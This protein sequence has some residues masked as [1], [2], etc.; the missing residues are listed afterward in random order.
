MPETTLWNRRFVFLLLAQTGFGFAHS[1]FLMLPKF[2]ATELAAGPAEIGGVVAVSAISIVLFL[3][4]AGSMVDRHGR[5]PFLVAGTLLMAV[6]SASYV[7]VHEI[8]AFLYALRLLQSLAFAY[9]FAAGGALCI[10]AAPPERIG[11]A[12]GL[13]GLSYIVMGAFAPAVVEGLVELRGWDACFWLTAATSTL[14]ATLSLFVREERVEPGATPHVPLTSIVA[15][16]EMRRATLVVGLLGIAFGCA[17]NFYQP[18]ALSL[19]ILELRDF[20]IAHSVAAASCRLALG[21]FIDRIGL[22][23]VSLGSLSLY[24]VVIFGMTWLDEIGLV[25]LGLGMG[26]AHGLFYPSYTGT[27]LMGCPAAERGRRMSIIQAGLNVGV[28][29]AGIVLGT[30]AAR[31]GYPIVFQIA[32][33]SL[34]LA[35]WLIATTPRP[36]PEP[37]P[38]VGEVAATAGGGLLPATGVAD[39]IREG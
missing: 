22:R 2:L 29:A 9:A 20:F 19:G 24:A 6:A 39:P 33:G 37:L 8:G 28:A 13:Y 3:I 34:L 25:L 23:R 26:L 5:K 1:A 15:R 31:W 10:D 32:T 16:P 38:D 4:P 21:P 11:Q 18:Y 35:A 12:L 17:F 7:L 27:V 14:C 30:V 36:A